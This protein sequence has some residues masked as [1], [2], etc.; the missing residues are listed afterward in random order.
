M[1]GLRSSDQISAI[2]AIPFLAN[3]VTTVSTWNML[4]VPLVPPCFNLKIVIF[5]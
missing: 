4:L 2:I 3:I 5:V 1:N